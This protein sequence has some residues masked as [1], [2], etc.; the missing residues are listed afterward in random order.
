MGQVAVFG[1]FDDPESFSGWNCRQDDGLADLLWRSAQTCTAVFKLLFSIQYN[2]KSLD[3]V[4][5]L[6]SGTSPQEDGFSLDL[7]QWEGSVL[8]QNYLHMTL[9][10]REPQNTVV[11]TY[12][13]VDS[14]PR[15]Y[16]YEKMNSVPSG[17]TRCKH[18]FLTFNTF[19]VF[20]HL[21]KLHLELKS[22]SHGRIKS[23]V[24]LWMKMD[25]G[26]KVNISSSLL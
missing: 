21:Q 24:V 26:R 25:L 20:P 3:F 17:H 19:S 10:C 18:N 22:E 16:R 14:S 9:W 6:E 23:C 7:N 2:G 8:Q 5:F 1:F 4:L 13:L 15:F 12:L 11:C